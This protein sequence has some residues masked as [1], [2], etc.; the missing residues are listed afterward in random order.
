[1]GSQTTQCNKD[2]M[3]W[4][5]EKGLTSIRKKKMLGL[6]ELTGSRSGYLASISRDSWN[7]SSG[8]DR[9]QYQKSKERE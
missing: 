8:V 9:F 3:K 2:R 4:I 6:G 1:M 7:R 5:I